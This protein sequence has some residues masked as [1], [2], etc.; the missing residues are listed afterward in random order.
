MLNISGSKDQMFIISVINLTMRFIFWSKLFTVSNAKNIHYY[1]TVFSHV[2]LKMFPIGNLSMYKIITWNLVPVKWHSI[3]VYSTPTTRFFSHFS[4]SFLSFLPARQR[5]ILNSQETDL[6]KH[7]K[8]TTNYL[9]YKWNCSAYP[10]CD[11][12]DSKRSKYICHHTNIQQN[13]WDNCETEVSK[14]LC[15]LLGSPIL[16]IDQLNNI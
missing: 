10:Y 16:A 7:N 3:L 12:S 1:C 6:E 15:D 13:K 11:R 14:S 8:V 9:S 5:E 2:Y 4:R